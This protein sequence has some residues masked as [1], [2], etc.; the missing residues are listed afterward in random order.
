MIAS[1][2]FGFRITKMIEQE[3]ELINLECDQVET[4]DIKLFIYH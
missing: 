3:L 4:N 2:H 1:Q